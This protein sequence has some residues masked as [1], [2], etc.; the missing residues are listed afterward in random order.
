MTDDDDPGDAKVWLGVPHPWPNN[1]E[2]VPLDAEL[3]EYVDEH[4]AGEAIVFL[5]T[6][7]GT[8]DLQVL[9]PE[10]YAE[11]LRR[12]KARQAEA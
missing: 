6:P 11:V 9:Q 8:L 3:Q 4:D 7:D 5:S 1:A 12:W 2:K 10:V